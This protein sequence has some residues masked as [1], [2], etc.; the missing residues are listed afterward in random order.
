MAAYRYRSL[1]NPFIQNEKELADCLAYSSG[2]FNMFVYVQLRP[3]YSLHL[4]PMLVRVTVLLSLVLATFA[5][6]PLIAQQQEDCR[7]K[8]EDLK[9]VIIRFNPYFTNHKWDADAQLEMAQMDEAHLLVIAQEGCKR[10]HIKFTMII[11][12]EVAQR[13]ADYWLEEVKSMMQKIYWERTDYDP[14]R[15]DFERVFEEKFKD[16]GLNS[17]FN[18]PLGSSN[19][20]CGI[21]Y[22]P[23]RGGRISIEKVSF[24]FKE[25]MGATASEAD[26]SDDGWLG[27]DDPRHDR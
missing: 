13:G 5:T 2:F 4:F 10:H 7:L 15:A 1:L 12:P 14:Y 18:F 6:R 8:V 16:Y 23:D 19:F 20:I 9:P 25:K 17:S 3:D 22:H 26:R 24:I 27:Q 21:F 11:D